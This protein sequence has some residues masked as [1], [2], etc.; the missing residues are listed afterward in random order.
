VQEKGEEDFEYINKR[1][2]ELLQE[3]IND[4]ITRNELTMNLEHY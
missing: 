3:A 1:K 2:L 4:E